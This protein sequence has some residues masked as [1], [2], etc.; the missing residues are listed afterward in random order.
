ML[1][2]DALKQIR[3]KNLADILDVL[4][5]KGACSLTQLAENTDGGLT[6]VTK[7]VRQAMGYGMILEGEPADSTGGR[8]PKQ[9]VLNE[10][11]QYFLFL[12]VDN[13]ALLCKVC[14][15][16]FA[17]I[18]EYTLHFTP[19]EYLSQIFKS[20]D[21]AMKK[22]AVGTICLSLP[23]VLKDG[24]VQDWFYNAQAVGF[25]VRAAISARY[26]CHVIVQNDMKL[27]VLGE[28][29]QNRKNVKNIVT[30]QF[31]HNGIGVGEM[32]NGNVLEG[33]SGFA[34]EVSYTADLRKN[35]MGV[36]YP[37][38]IVRNIVI[39]LNPEVI[40]FY[41]SSKQN[42]FAEIF[43]TAMKGLPAYAV[44]EYEISDAYYDRIVNGFLL[45]INQNVYYKKTEAENEQKQD[46]KR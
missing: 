26:P 11:Y 17:P 10:A 22:Y 1:E 25:D 6:T 38:K 45:L 29:A 23:C 28:R 5:R 31:G 3:N 30:V 12:I 16:A 24:V 37:A 18:E 19:T 46:V 35:I 27:T 36:A 20:I 42:Q 32:I 2:Q 4:R 34:G 13:D 33:A 39:Y 44:P 21:S 43:K 40:V 41:R 9:Y 8:K 15:F 14:N 7:C